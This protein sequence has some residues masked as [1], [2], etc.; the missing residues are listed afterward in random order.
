MATPADV[1]RELAGLSEHI[2]KQIDEQPTGVTP[3]YSAALG[4]TVLPNGRVRYVQG[5]P[6][7]SG[8][9]LL[10]FQRMTASQSVGSSAH[11]YYNNSLVNVDGCVSFGSGYWEFEAPTD[12]YY[13]FFANVRFEEVSSGWS[14]GHQATLYLTVNGGPSY[15]F[16]LLDDPQNN[17]RNNVVRGFALTYADAGDLITV[18]LEQTSGASMTLI[19]GYGEY[20]MAIKTGIA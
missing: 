12:G 8:L 7:S 2:A 1:A 18:K 16:G 3:G 5:T 14:A 11:V 15:Q 9:A 6:V 4:G 20:V 19:G 10:A 17:T 13:V